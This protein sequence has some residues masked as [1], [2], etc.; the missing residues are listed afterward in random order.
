MQRV[1]ILA[2]LLAAITAQAVAQTSDQRAGSEH[3][4]ART[5]DGRA[6]RRGAHE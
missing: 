5:A 6:D 3:C 2:G 4:R 1:L